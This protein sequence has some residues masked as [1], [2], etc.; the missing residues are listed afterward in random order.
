MGDTIVV[1]TRDNYVALASGT[2]V[3]RYVVRSVLGQGSFGI[4]YLAHDGQLGCEVAIKEYLPT[5]LAGRHDGVNV[6]PNST[7]AAEEFDPAT[8]PPDI[9]ALL[10]KGAK[11]LE[12]LDDVFH[13]RADNIATP[14]APIV[15]G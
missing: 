4:T 7:K 11:G 3:G 5:A 10:P 1:R 14:I 15:A 8:A 13:A 9:T 2:R 6:L 12:V